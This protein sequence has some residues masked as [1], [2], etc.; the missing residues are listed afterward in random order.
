M[1]ILD[2]LGCTGSLQE[3]EQV[4]GAGSLEGGVDVKK[5]AAEPPHSTRMFTQ[6]IDCTNIKRLSRKTYRAGIVA[7]SRKDKCGIKVCPSGEAGQA[8]WGPE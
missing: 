4:R 6:F 1:L 8:E 5:A 7:Q 3:Q 2:G